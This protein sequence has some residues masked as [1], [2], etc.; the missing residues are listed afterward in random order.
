MTAMTRTS[1]APASLASSRRGLR[2]RQK[3]REERGSP[4]KHPVRERMVRTRSP[5][6]L[7]MRR[8]WLGVG[9]VG[10]PP[11]W[12]ETRLG[13]RAR[14]ISPLS[15]ELKAFW[16]SV[17]TPVW[18]SR[19]ALRRRAAVSAPPG[20]RVNP[21]E[22]SRVRDL[23]QGVGGGHLVEG[24]PQR[25]WADARCSLGDSD[26]G[27]RKEEEAGLVG[28]LPVADKLNDEGKAPEAVGVV[29]EGEPVVASETTRVGSWSSRP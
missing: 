19:E 12:S 18:D 24:L 23:L 28:Q 17:D 4:C 15:I 3:R 13:E 5:A 16:T 29:E 26:K 25:D 10:N 6:W 8:D 9:P 21:S 27:A 14:R 22:P 11:E 7:W 1:G 2:A 20:W